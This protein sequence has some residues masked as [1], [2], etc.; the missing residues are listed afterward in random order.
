MEMDKE[1]QMKVDIQRRGGR[2][3]KEEKEVKIV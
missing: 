1:M 3:G 2:E